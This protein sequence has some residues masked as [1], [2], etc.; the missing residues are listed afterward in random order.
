M[1]G[2]HMAVSADT[3]LDQYLANSVSGSSLG[4]DN[5][6]YTTRGDKRFLLSTDEPIAR[7]SIPHGNPRTTVDALGPHQKCFLE[8][9]SQFLRRASARCK[10]DSFSVAFAGTVHE[11]M[12]PLGGLTWGPIVNLGNFVAWAA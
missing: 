11:S 5:D 8:G 10:T 1:R 7:T 9:G 4:G 6:A 2:R 12:R 3:Q